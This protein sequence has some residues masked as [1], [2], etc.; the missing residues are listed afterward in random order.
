MTGLRVP[1]S[2]APGHVSLALALRALRARFGPTAAIQHLSD[3]GVRGARVTLRERGRV[4]VL[5][6]CFS[7]DPETRGQLAA[8]WALQGGGPA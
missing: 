4:F 7:G 1:P 2:R 6:T 3:C 5:A 8:Q